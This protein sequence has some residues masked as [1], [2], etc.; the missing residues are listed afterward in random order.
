MGMQITETVLF[1]SSW[2][3]S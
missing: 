2:C 3:S 1:W